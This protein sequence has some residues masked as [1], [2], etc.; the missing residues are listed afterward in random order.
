M[1]GNNAVY[2]QFAPNT[3]A[4]QNVQQNVGGG[5]VVVQGQNGQFAQQFGQSVPQT[6]PNGGT[7]PVGGNAQQ[8]FTQEQVNA[9]VSGRVNDINTR[10]KTLEGQN[11]Q[12]QALI[13]QY[14][15]EIENYK[16]R[17]TL[18]QLGVQSY[19]QEWVGFEANKLA[20]NGKTFEDAVKEVI[21]KNPFILTSTV[22]QGQ[23]P[24][25]NPQLPNGNMGG[26]QGSANPVNNPSQNQQVNPN[27][28]A[29][30][31]G[32][33]QF[34][35]TQ[36]N[37]QNNQPVGFTNNQNTQN[38]QGGTVQNQQVQQQGAMFTGGTGVTGQSGGITNQSFDVKSFLESRT[39]RK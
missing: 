39:K 32:N 13:N 16:R 27:G 11:S 30:V 12:L 3:G 23:A 22:T 38:F 37:A 7:A 31:G 10:Y 29:N 26:S 2:G 35:N 15:Q 17:D 14:T 20:V 5:A 8:M 34:G 19:M 24:Q 4:G 9:I 36:P 28:M 33:T 1:E 25:V 6:N 18:T 21:S